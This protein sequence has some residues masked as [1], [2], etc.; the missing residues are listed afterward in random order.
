MDS[1]IS[2]RGTWPITANKD[3]TSRSRFSSSPPKSNRQTAVVPKSILIPGPRSHVACN[4]HQ[5]LPRVVV[6]GS[7]PPRTK[8]KIKNAR[9]F[10]RLV[11]PCLSSREARDLSLILVPGILYSVLHHDTT[12]IPRI[13]PSPACSSV[14]QNVSCLSFFPRRSANV[15]PPVSAPSILIASEPVRLLPPRSP[16]AGILDESVPSVGSRYLALLT[17]ITQRPCVSETAT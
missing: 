8:Y 2:P 6:S 10:K 7:N 14:G 3:L 5:S 13:L 17:V 9:S 4:S 12:H 11:N 1:P 16:E 15:E